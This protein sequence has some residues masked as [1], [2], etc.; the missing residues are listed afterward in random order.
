MPPRGGLN[1]KCFV[2]S[3]LGNIAGRGRVTAS[4]YEAKRKKLIQTPIP[5]QPRP[6]T[7]TVR[8][9]AVFLNLSEAWVYRNLTSHD[10]IPHYRLNSTLRFLPEEVKEWVARHRSG[11]EPKGLP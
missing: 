6:Q 9:V 11:S 4:M 10:P 7:W 3:H 2:C 5:Y 1:Y 8:T